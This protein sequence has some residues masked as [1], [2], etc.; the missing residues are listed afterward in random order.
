MP[1]A[2]AA[3]R[4]RFVAR[5]AA[6]LERR[7]SRDPLV[8][9]ITW[10]PGELLF[11]TWDEMK[12]YL[13]YVGVE[14]GVETYRDKRT[15]KKLYAGRTQPSLTPEQIE[16]VAKLREE[17]N[18]ILKPLLPKVLAR[19]PLGVFEKRTVKKGAALLERVLEIVPEE[20]ATRWTLGMIAR[21]DEVQ[22]YFRS[23]VDVERR[24]RFAGR[25]T[26]GGGTARPSALARTS[27]AHPPLSCRAAAPPLSTR[28]MLEASTCEEPLVCSEESQ[29]EDLRG[30]CQEAIRGIVVL[31]ADPS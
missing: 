20:W 2:S 7:V 6:C 5:R 11:G 26:A 18:A 9:S 12:E 29:T 8:V 19:K 23:A 27:R 3:L 21:A 13:E 31:D 28:E 16:R 30:R 22:G 17:A 4:R 15:G 14:N 10:K 1:E 25:V 24:S